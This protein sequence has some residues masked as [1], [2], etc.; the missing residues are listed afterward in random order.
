MTDAQ[1]PLS[2]RDGDLALHSPWSPDRACILH[3]PSFEGQADSG[4][5]AITQR[6]IWTP[7]ASDPRRY[8]FCLDAPPEAIGLGFSGV[9]TAVSPA[10]I[11][12][13]FTLL[14]ASPET[15]QMGRQIMFLGLGELEEFGDPDGRGTVV[16]TDK[17]WRPR[18][19]L[20]LRGKPVGPHGSIR[21]G[22]SYDGATIIWD[23]V[24]RINGG[25]NRI[26]ALAMNRAFALSTDHPDWGPG[27]LA[28]LRW[29]PLPAGED[30][31]ARG[32]VFLLETSF[33]DLEDR[34]LANRKR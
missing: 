4:G 26:A 8:A 12:F 11:R 29:G 14:N 7:D 2:V 25:R 32:A 9:V 22:T 18:A 10:E 30:Q 23:M 33:Q 13:D 31:T 34:F 5:F 6:L 1:L 16:Y 27:L 28:A 21:V 3:L 24:V 15:L 17:G 19:A 20:S